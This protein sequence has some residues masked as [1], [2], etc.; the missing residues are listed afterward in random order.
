MET[1]I[2]YK[3]VSIT[4]SLYRLGTASFPAYL[5]LGKDAMIIEGG[6]GAT[7]NILVS[8]I[9]ELGIEPGRIKYLALT[10]SHSDHIGAVPHLKKLWPHLEILAGE[11]TAASLKDDAYISAATEADNSLTQILINKGEIA[12]APQSIAN[13][14]I[15]VGHIIKDKDMI[16]LG[17]GVAWRVIETPGH[18][19]CHTSYFEMKERIVAIGDATGFYA[20]DKDVFWPNYFDSLKNYC[21]SILK[22]RELPAAIGVLSHNYIVNENVSSFLKKAYDATKNYHYDLIRRV[23]SDGIEKFVTENADWVNSLTTDHPYKLMMNLSKI[24]VKRSFAE[25]QIEI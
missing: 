2:K 5:S 6:I 3:P 24:L 16:D 7:F 15:D 11:V 10:H 20:P 12:E 17:D 25:S 4:G 22:L 19:P 18:S 1:T 14:R 8:Q 9:A 23:N 13:R 21:D